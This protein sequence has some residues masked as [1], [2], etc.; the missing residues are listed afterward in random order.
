MIDHLVNMATF[1]LGQWKTSAS[2]LCVQ[3]FIIS[4]VYIY[5]IGVSKTIL[6]EI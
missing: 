4:L 1:Q 3:K 6:R 5:V 2:Y